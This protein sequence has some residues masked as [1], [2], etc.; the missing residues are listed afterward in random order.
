MSFQYLGKKVT[1]NKLKTTAF[2]VK[3]TLNKYYKRWTSLITFFFFQNHK[4]QA[5]ENFYSY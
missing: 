2:F 4:L 5:R 1:Q 3:Q